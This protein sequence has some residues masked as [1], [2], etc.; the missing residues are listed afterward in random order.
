MECSEEESEGMRQEINRE[1]L[2]RFPRE[3]KR[4]GVAGGGSFELT[5]PTS[6]TSHLSGAWDLLR[7]ESSLRAN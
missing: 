7:A 1:L 6:R 2:N 4:A 3:E 5:A